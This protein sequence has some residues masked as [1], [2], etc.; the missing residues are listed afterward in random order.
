MA[1]AR[2]RAVVL[3]SAHVDLVAQAPSL[4]TPGASVLGTEVREGP[5]GKAANQAGQLVQLGVETELLARVGRD[6]RGDGLAAAFSTAGIGTD[7][8]VRDNETATGISLVL[9]APGDYA[10]IIVPGAAGRL[11]TADVDDAADAIRAAQILLLQLEVPAAASLRA[12]DIALAS[13][14]LVLVNVSPPLVEQTDDARHL[15]QRASILVMNEA[16]AEA[17]IGVPNVPSAL[18]AIPGRF[19]A[20]CVI[21]TKGDRGAVAVEDGRFV[22]QAAY[23]VDVIDTVGAGDAFLA[24][25]AAARIE[26]APLEACLARGAAA[27]AL[28]ASRRGA[29]GAFASRRD[30]DRLMGANGAMDRKS[31]PR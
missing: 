27:G 21:V 16:E 20:S 14:R 5:G 7:L 31:T 24:A 28:V 29:F 2:P 6:A 15:L 22:E 11:S 13:G 10:S 30:I 25:F 17:L 9:S 3:G 23:R 1:G 4:P 18:S 26:D 8:L 12:A 19:G